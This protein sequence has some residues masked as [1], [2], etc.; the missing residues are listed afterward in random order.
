MISV[1]K[2]E[3]VITSVCEE[4]SIFEKIALINYII[5]RFSESLQNKIKDLSGT[6]KP[7]NFGCSI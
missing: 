7:L 2:K 3:R 5:E 4:N 6:A 1:W